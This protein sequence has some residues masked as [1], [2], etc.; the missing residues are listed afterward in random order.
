[1]ASRAP[2]SQHGGRAS[3]ASSG[4]GG[5]AREGLGAREVRQGRDGGRARGSKG[6][7]SRG[8]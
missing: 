4:G 5:Y 8:A 2:G 1:M 3:P 6:A 7:T